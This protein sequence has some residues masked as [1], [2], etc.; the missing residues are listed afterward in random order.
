MRILTFDIEEWFHLL[1]N[2]S[3]G[4]ESRWGSFPV[5]IHD[6]VDRLL[7][8]LS[9]TDTKATFFILG[10]IAEQYPEVVARIAERYEIGSHTMNHELVWARDRA[11]FRNDV[12][13]S[14]KLLE[15]VSGRRV[16]YFRAPGFSIRESEPWAFEVLH[17]CGIEIDCSVF[18]ARHAH[19]G[20]E[21]YGEAGPSIVE[22]NGIRIKELPVGF[23]EVL[24]KNIIYSG[25]GYFRLLPY[26]LIRRWTCRDDYVMSYIHPRDLDP[27]Q[28]RLEGLSAARRFKAYVGIHGA[29]RKLRR[30]L[31]D[32]E[33]TDIASADSRIKWDEVPLVRLTVIS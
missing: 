16:K 1:E 2:E 13:R 30:W 6:N 10:W 31:T 21:H 29:E 4:D 24:G 12:E 15:D 23:H 8:I 33:F 7:E 22:H 19:G 5:R 26:R 28:P 14:V 17:E 20:I 3:T 27:G 25:G 18:P 9:D 11:A 32:F